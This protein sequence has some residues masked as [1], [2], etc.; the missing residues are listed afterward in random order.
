MFGMLR[1][2]IAF[3]GM[4]MILIGEGLL[5]SKAYRRNQVLCMLYRLRHGRGRM[6]SAKEALAG[7]RGLQF[8]GTYGGVSHERYVAPSAHM[9]VYVTLD[10]FVRVYMCASL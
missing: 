5:D 7:L 2:S 1:R 10:M 9:R 6:I 4:H 8:R 3:M